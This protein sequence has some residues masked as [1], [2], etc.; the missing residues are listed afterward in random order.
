MAQ[1]NLA[2][3]FFRLLIQKLIKLHYF[4]YHLN[5]GLADL[6]V[7]QLK[8]EKIND[9]IETV[10]KKINFHD[11]LF[12]QVASRQVFIVTAIIFMLLGVLAKVAALFVNIPYPVL[13]GVIIST[14]G[15]FVG[16]NLS[17]LRVVD[18][19]STRNLSIMGMAI[20]VGLLVPEWTEE[21]SE[22][23]KT[24]TVYRHISVYDKMRLSLL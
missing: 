22:A 23:I 6:S 5:I 18:L 11:I 24:G 10:C 2:S 20:F 8:T 9:L 7:S 21:N 14:I 4:L 3:I 17:N 15:V 19:S 1:K 12:C 13:G 16:V